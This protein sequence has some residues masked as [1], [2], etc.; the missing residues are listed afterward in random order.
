MLILLSV[1]KVDAKNHAQENN[2]QPQPATVVLEEAYV[3]EDMSAPNL[4]QPSE[5]L[6]GV[7]SKDVEVSPIDSQAP[8]PM[9]ASE[10]ETQVKEEMILD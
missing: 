8:T 6:E 5:M 10:Q 1:G 4:K 2:V 7:S 3:Q 9:P